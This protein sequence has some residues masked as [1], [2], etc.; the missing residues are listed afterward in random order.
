MSDARGNVSLRLGILEAA[1]RASRVNHQSL[2]DQIER[3]A[4]L[5][6]ALEAHPAFLAANVDAVVAGEKTVEELS[7]LERIAFFE[8]IP[9]IFCDPSAELIADYA[10]SSNE[11]STGT[12]LRDRE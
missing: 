7:S 5:G 6:C 2:A 10:S 11:P 9:K 3:W 1:T 8:R 4:R 12:N